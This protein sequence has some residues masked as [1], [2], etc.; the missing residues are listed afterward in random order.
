MDRFWNIMEK[1]KSGFKRI[2]GTETSHAAA[3]KWR[4]GYL[5]HFSDHQLKEM[6]IVVYLEEKKSNDW[7]KKE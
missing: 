6:G 1:D 7:G 5:S 2:I 3:K 4:K